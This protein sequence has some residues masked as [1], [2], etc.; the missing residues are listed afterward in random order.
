[1]RLAN[2]FTAKMVASIIPIPLR[3][4]P[5]ELLPINLVQR[6]IKE[7]STQ[8]YELLTALVSHAANGKRHLS[9]SRVLLAHL[10]SFPDGRHH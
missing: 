6:R 5:Q 3:E 4:P 9:K 10:G 2:F 8:G 1:M 7:L